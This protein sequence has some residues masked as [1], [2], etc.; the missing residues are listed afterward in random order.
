M[1]TATLKVKALCRQAGLNQSLD[2]LLRRLNP[3]LRGW[4][5]YFRPGVSSRIFSW[6]SHDTWQRVWRWLRRKHRQDTIAELRRLYRHGGWW[7]ADQK[8]EM[9]NPEKVS[10]TRY[11]YRSKVIPSPWPSPDEEPHPA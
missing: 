1:Q 3:M 6:L 9:F 10:T 2:D 4:C 11:R 5:G 7:P 8:T